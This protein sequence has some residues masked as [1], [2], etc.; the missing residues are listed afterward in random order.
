[1][2]KNALKEDLIRVVEELDGIVESTDTIVKLKTKIEN[3]STFE[4]DPDFVKTLIQNCIDER[5][6]QNEREVTSEQKIELAKLQLAKLEKE[7]ELQL[8]KNKALSLNPAAKVEEKQFETNIENMIKSIKTLSHPVPTRSENFNLFFQS[9]ERAFLTKKINDEY[10]SEILINLLG[11][12][13]HNVL[14]RDIHQFAARLTANFQ[15]YCSLRK[16]NS[17][18]SLCDLI[19]SDKLYETLNKE[20]ATHIGIR[21]AEDWFRPIDLAKECDIYISSRSG[22]HKE[23]PITYGYTQDPFKNR[24][25]NFKPKIKENYPQ[26]LERENKNCYICGDSSHCAR[27]CEKRFKPKES[28]DH[29]HNKINVN[30]LKIESEKQNSDECANLQY[31]NIFVENQPVTALID[32]GCQIPVLNSSLIRVQ[33]PSEEI[34]TLSSCFGEQRM[35]EVKP[36]NISLNQHSTSLSVRTA[37]SPTLTEEF[38]IHPSVYSEI[39]K[40]GNAKS[41]VLLSE[42]GSSLSADCGVSFPNVSVSNVI[43]NSSYDLPYVKNF[44]T[45]NDSSSLIKDY[46]CNKIKSTKLKLS[47]VREKCSDIVLCKKANG[48]MK[49]SSVEFISRSPNPLPMKSKHHRFVLLRK[50]F[51]PWQWKRRKKRNRFEQASR[52]LQRK[53]SM[54]STKDQLVEKDVLMPVKHNVFLWNLPDV[55]EMPSHD[56][57]TV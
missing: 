25:Q 15:Y 19:I 38:I 18:E 43:E 37:I 32:S 17:F 10:K 1:M 34:I 4:S 20:T 41:D 12:R 52:T 55:G 46:K 49:T 42:S 44:N 23:I 30:T 28:N 14:L 39:K 8:A 53:I 35:V 21:E 3:S 45:R 54:R 47:I 51:E 40:L 48:A 13:A 6:S 22:S 29:I 26:Y 57:E 7:I 2:Y 9:L 24:S 56:G 11:E 5:V 27:D 36:I 33:T 16:V 31:V 50:I